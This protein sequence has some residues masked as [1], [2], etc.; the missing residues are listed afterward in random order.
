RLQ[1]L[2][3]VGEVRLEPVDAA[4]LLAGLHQ[5]AELAMLGDQRRRVVLLAVDQGQAQSQLALDL[6]EEPTEAGAAEQ[7]PETLR[8][9]AGAYQSIEE[10]VKLR[11][12]RLSD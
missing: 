8:E 12:G 5:L 11:Y 10:P 7:Y 2:F 4:L 6:L 1:D 9:D 3:A